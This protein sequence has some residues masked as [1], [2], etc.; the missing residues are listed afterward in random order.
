[1]SSVM[2]Q[3]EAS[4]HLYGA[5]APFV[6]ELYE[7]YLQDPASVS[8]E[9]RAQF[10]A[11]QA[12]G[13]GQDVAHTPVIEA[14]AAAAKRGHGAAAT[15]VA[16][17]DEKQMKVLMFIRAHRTTG[18]HY[19]NLDPLMRMDHVSVPELE[20]SYYGLGEADLDK[21]FSMGSF[22][23]HNERRTLREIVALVRKTYCNTIG[24][25]YMYLSSMEE[26]RWLRERFEGTLSTPSLNERQKRFLL[27]RISASETL[28]R[29]LHTRYVGQ[30]RF[31]GEGGESLVPLLDIVIEEA[32]SQGAKEV[33]IGMAHRG[34][35]NVLVNNLG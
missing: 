4:S 25:E 7:R 11:W 32:G 27:E 29:Y 33:V 21:V 17:D 20:L 1:M 9:W 14:F 10:D 15:A 23:N 5:N 26:K 28:E 22:A 12:A 19:S 13:G 18:S 16:A 30:K 6:E 24:V 31:S 3:F 34:R 2:K 35:L 8:P